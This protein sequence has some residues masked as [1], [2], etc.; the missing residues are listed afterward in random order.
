MPRNEKPQEINAELQMAEAAEAQHQ[1]Q[2]DLQVEDPEDGKE[3]LK[4]LLGGQQ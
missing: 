3:R 2:A 4:N 1:T